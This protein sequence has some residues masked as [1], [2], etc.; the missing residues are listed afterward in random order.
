MILRQLLGK[1]VTDM[2]FVTRQQLDEA[3]QR[4]KKILEKRRLA[5]RLQRPSL[6]SE[7]RLTKDTTPILGNLLVDMGF[8]TRQQLGEALEEQD[9]SIEVYKSL[10]SGKLGITIEI[11][12]LVNSTLNLN[13]VLIII[14]RHVNQVTNSVSSTLMMLD[15][16]T[17]ELV[18]SLPTGPGADKLT[19]IRL[20]RGK[21]IAGWV[22]QH[23]QPVLLRDAREDPRFYPEI[24]KIRGIQTKSILCVPVKSKAKL[25][26]VLEVINK[27]DNTSFTE[28]DA[29]F[30]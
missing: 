11:G 3:L 20:P 13:E 26:G 9:R 14:M 21:G 12:S 10:E 6:V 16:K 23:E 1:I 8:V 25:I 4:Q 18:F 22:A 24:D 17:G 27:V 7:A 15:D 2:G 19:D 28:E 5:E 30:L 29:F